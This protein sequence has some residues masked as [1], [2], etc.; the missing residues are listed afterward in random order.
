MEIKNLEMVQGETKKYTVIM[1]FNIIGG[2][3]YFTIKRDYTDSDDNAVIQ[4]TQS[5]LPDG[6][7]GKAEIVL[8]STQTRAIP[9]GKYVYDIRFIDNLGAVTSVAGGSFTVRPTVTQAII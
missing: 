8:P 5:D 2:K 7:S 3:F 4:I 1:P 9:V 6:I